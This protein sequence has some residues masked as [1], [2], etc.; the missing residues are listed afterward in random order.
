[1]TTTVSLPLAE[2]EEAMAH[3]GSRTKKEAAVIALAEF[4]R[5]RRL[6]KLADQFGSLEGFMSQDELARMPSEG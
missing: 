1:M 6:A 3:T 2:L 4:N 5:R